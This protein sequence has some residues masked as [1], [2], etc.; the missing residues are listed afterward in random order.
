MTN[1]QTEESK[2]QPYDTRLQEKVLFS[3]SDA[4]DQDSR[5]SELYI[6]Q[7]QFHLLNNGNESKFLVIERD[8]MKGFNVFMENVTVVP[9]SYICI[10]YAPW[11]LR[12][13][14]SKVCGSVAWPYVH[15]RDNL[16]SKWKWTE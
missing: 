7:C 3:F 9:S 5:E 8:D 11:W 12:W 4:D 10:G 13:L 15:S 1:Q 2:R 14:I 16:N 6:N